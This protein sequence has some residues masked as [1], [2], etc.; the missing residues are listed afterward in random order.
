MSGL[1]TLSELFEDELKDVYNAEQQ[2]LKAL[3][4]VIQ[5]V[6]NHDLRRALK[7]HLTE[8][9]TQVARLERAFRSLD[10]KPRGKHCA[11]MAGILEEGN[12]I[13]KEDGNDAVLDAALIAGCQ[14][15]EHYEITAYG[16]LVAWAKELGYSEARRLL[17]QNEREEKA[18]DKKLSRIATRV[19]PA[20]RAADDSDD[21]G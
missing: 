9:R 17:Q 5:A 1:K 2:I 11:G 7:S 20:A 18:A 21:E 15:V 12:D 10:L 16:S 14:R 6:A 19:N 3:P 4:K 13:L 8:T